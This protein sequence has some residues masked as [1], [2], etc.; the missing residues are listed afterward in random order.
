MFAGITLSILAA[1]LKRANPSA[2]PHPAIAGVVGATLTNLP[3][4]LEPA[5]HPNHRAFFHSVVAGGLIAAGVHRAW[6]WTPETDLDRLLR[7]ITLLV[8]SA[9][10]C[11]LLL[12]ALTAKS[13]PLYGER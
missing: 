3:D 6:Y 4:L 2:V 11:H 12:D 13:L 10:L 8:G 5:I 7:G 9:Y 1:Q